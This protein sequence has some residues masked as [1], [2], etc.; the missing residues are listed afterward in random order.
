MKIFTLLS[1]LFCSIAL[2]A[3]PVLDE[4]DFTPPLD[5]PFNLSNAVW[6]DPGAAG[7]NVTWDFSEMTEISSSSV[8]YI[9]MSSVAGAANF[10]SGTHAFDTGIGIVEVF[11][12]SAAGMDNLGFDAGIASA[13]Y[14]DPETMITFPFNFEDSGSDDFEGS[15]AGLVTRTGTVTFEYD[16]YG[17]LILPSGTVEN[18]A[19]VKVTE[20]Y[21]D[22]SS[23]GGDSVTSTES[24]IYVQQD[25]G[26]PIV[27]IFESDVDGTVTNGTTYSAPAPTHISMT[28]D[29]DITVF[30]N[31]ANNVFMISGQFD[32]GT[33]IELFDLNGRAVAA[34]LVTSNTLQQVSVSD[35][36]A[37]LYVMRATINGAIHQAT[38][39]V[40]R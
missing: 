30:P 38:V 19:R 28:A 12:T 15:V 2:V 17:T 16:G 5:A 37:G 40:V 29:N 39:S 36:P 14:S 4:N 22:S 24:Y 11:S 31:P 23:L 21:T 1:F 20:N 26:Y 7:A 32:A 13:V 34:Q 33:Q 18:V 8:S 6:M 35:L 9:P 10:P 25:L 27:E 3:Q